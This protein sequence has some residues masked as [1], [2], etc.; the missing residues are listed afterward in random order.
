VIDQPLSALICDLHVSAS[1][2]KF[3][4]DSG[5]LPESPSRTHGTAPHRTGQAISGGMALT[6]RFDWRRYYHA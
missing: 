2:A 4:S 1:P 3:L 5:R 6:C